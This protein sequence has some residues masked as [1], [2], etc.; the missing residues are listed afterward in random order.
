MR[1]IGHSPSWGQ[2]SSSS[3]NS[4]KARTFDP[5]VIASGRIDLREHRSTPRR[6]RNWTRSMGSGR[7]VRHAAGSCWRVTVSGGSP[8]THV[9]GEQCPSM[10]IRCQERVHPDHSPPDKRPNCGSTVWLRTA[11]TKIAGAHE[12]NSTRRN[13]LRHNFL[14]QKALWSRDFRIRPPFRNAADQ[15]HNQS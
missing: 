1:C 12:A 5:R 2:D 15:A 7:L 10:G 6:K 11:A 13:S 14:V 9:D 3:R 4:S 8:G